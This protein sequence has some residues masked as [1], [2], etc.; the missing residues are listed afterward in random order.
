MQAV[1]GKK[2]PNTKNNL[3]VRPLK[4][5]ADTSRTEDIRIEIIPLIDV[6]FSILIFFILSAVGY[7]RQQAINLD[8]PKANTGTAQ[9]QE[10]L[11]V[12]LDDF[13]QVYV[14]Q[15]SVVTRNDL[16][17]RINQYHQN[18]PAGL[19]V[20]QASA[21]ASYDEVIQVLDVLREVGGDRVALATLPKAGTVPAPIET[22]P[23][24]PTMPSSPNT[25][26]SPPP[27]LPSPGGTEGIPQQELQQELPMTPP[28]TE[29][30]PSQ[31]LPMTPP[32][33]G[34]DE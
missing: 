4:L 17:Q 32:G 30:T 33:E 29:G 5:W 18:N 3:P 10:M 27:G 2:T 22:T 6:I 16:Y 12:S 19:M 13:G 9:M 23:A 25:E 28:G 8:L 15:D 7:S 31:E 34:S 1:P 24:P 20:L 11:I 26:L 14:E 21:S